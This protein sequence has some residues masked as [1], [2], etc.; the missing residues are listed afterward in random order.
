MG[1]DPMETP[2]GDFAAY[3][4]GLAHYFAEWK[5]GNLFGSKGMIAVAALNR[6]RSDSLVKEIGHAYSRLAKSV[7]C[8]AAFKT[9]V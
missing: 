1:S 7:S 6:F 9:K 8:D 3:A 2:N 5:S 4:D